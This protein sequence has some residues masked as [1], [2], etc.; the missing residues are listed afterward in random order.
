[1]AEALQRHGVPQA[2][3]ETY[4]RYEPSAPK[5]GMLTVAFHRKRGYLKRVRDN[6]VGGVATVVTSPAELPK[7]VMETGRKQGPVAGG[8]KGVVCGF[9]S[10]LRRAG[11]GAVRILTFWAG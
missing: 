8:T 7:G 2:Q 4:G 3:M 5:G 10:T 6:L 1:M 9:G 11:T